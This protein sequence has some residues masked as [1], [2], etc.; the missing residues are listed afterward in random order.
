MGI[1]SQL[2]IGNWPNIGEKILKIPVSA[3]KKMISVDFQADKIALQFNLTQHRLILALTVIF[4]F[5]FN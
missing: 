4:T 5:Y 3:T 1:G 2:N